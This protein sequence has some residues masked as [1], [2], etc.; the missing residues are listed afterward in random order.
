MMRA[1]ASKQEYSSGDSKIEAAPAGVWGRQPPT[2][3]DLT[4]QIQGQ[5]ANL[6]N[7]NG[8]TTDRVNGRKCTGGKRGSR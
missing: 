6:V 7:E 8:V 5:L 4:V 2:V 3:I 1:Y